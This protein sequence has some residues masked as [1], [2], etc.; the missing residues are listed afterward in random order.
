MNKDRRRG[1]IPP[2]V[3]MFNQIKAGTH[4]V[5]RAIR[6]KQ[7]ASKEGLVLIIIAA[8]LQCFF[9]QVPEMDKIR[10]ADQHPA[11]RLA[12]G[13]RLASLSLVVRVKCH[14]VLKQHAVPE[15]I[16]FRLIVKPVHIKIS[17]LIPFP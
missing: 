10:G 3:L 7:A 13:T 6:L 9:A 2:P 5:E 1:E 4:G 17:F 11:K 15:P 16:A 8:P 14:T 12:K